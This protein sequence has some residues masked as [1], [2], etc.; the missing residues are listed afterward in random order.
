MCF[1]IATGYIA[2]KL[3]ARSL[4][5][6]LLTM[7]SIVGF[8]YFYSTIGMETPLFLLLIVLSLYLYKK[9]SDYFVISLAFLVI[10]RSEG[11]FLA[12]PI[13]LDYLIRYKKIPK[14]SYVVSGLVILALPFIFNK[15]YLG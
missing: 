5:G 3:F 6:Q 9:D 14:T 8:G 4:F 12:I 7:L 15:L 1:L 2:S 11:I 10:T 13:C